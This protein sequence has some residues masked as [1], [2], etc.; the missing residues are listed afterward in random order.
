V[1]TKRQEQ[2]LFYVSRAAEGVSQAEVDRIL[3]SSQARNLERR[4]TGMLLF[5]G[6]YFAQVLEGE[7]QPLE[8]VMSSIVAD[9]RH[10]DI[11]VL[12]RQPLGRR[13]FRKW[14]MGCVVRL[15][16][17]DLI[18]ELTH[19]PEVPPQRAERLVTS[20]FS[21]GHAERR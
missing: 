2:W 8:A 9:A 10:R 19:A 12:A 11:R 5:T 14:S 17:S 15:G 7:A 4:L 21:D 16:M 13:R 6:A 3:R 18:E 1:Q 20:L